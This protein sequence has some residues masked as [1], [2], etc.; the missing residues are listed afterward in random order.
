[1][2]RVLT[3]LKTKRS[4]FYIK[5]KNH[6]S[7]SFS[8]IEQKKIC[9]PE[10]D[11]KPMADNTKQFNWIVK[12]KEGFELLFENNPDV[13]VAGDLLWYPVQGN[14]KIRV[15]PDTMIVFGR[16]KGDRGS[17]RSWDE[18]NIN[19]QIVFEILSPGNTKK[20]MDRKLKFY[21]RYK[22][23]EYYIYDPDK[24]IFSVYIRSG[25]EL[26]FIDN[27]H[28][29]VSPLLKVRFESNQETLR[30]FTPD[31]QEF[32]S[33]LEMGLERNAERKRSEKISLERDAEYQRAE[34]ERKRAETERKRA[35]VLTAKLK[36]LG[37]IV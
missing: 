17:Y 30:I 23:E 13:F 3:P 31:G 37:V 16:P 18:D 15:A 11:G 26:N 33:P 29:W 7:V 35:E 22:V 34:T 19:P 9:Y 24:N 32:I 14:N 2:N 27:I 1:M 10:S 4:G 21:E 28:G 6:S 12:I 5:F 36:E 25:T 20:E 8:P